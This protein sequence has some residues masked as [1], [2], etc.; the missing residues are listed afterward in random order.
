MIHQVESGL[1]QRKGKALTNF[2][3]TLPKQQSDLA[4]EVLKNPYNLDFLSLGAESNER[5]LENALIANIKK[6]LLE[7][8]TGFSFMGQQYYLKVGE[9]EYYIDLLFYHTRLHCYVVVELKV[10]EF[11]PEFAGKLEFYLTAVDEQLKTERDEPTIGLLLC[12]SMDRVVVEY[13]LRNKLKPMSVAAYK[14][15]IPKEL[16]DELPTEEALKEQLNIEVVIPVKPME[17]KLARLK[18]LIAQTG[19]EKMEKE[20]D[21]DEVRYLFNEFI[22]DFEKAV[23]QNL[24]EITNEFAKVEIGRR[25]NNTSSPYFMAADLEATLEKEAVYQLGLGIRMEG[26]K[27]GGTKAFNIFKDLIINLEQYK[28][29]VGTEQHKPWLEK[30]YHQKW[31]KEEVN[32]LADKWCEQL[33]DEIADRIEQLSL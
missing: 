24:S 8:G 11:V 13:S 2:E 25:I 14:H 20:R 28:Y 16:R 5:D 29:G 4:K 26:F 15:A 9:K 12:K 32:N 23:K 10:T 6:F 19:R 17:E 7:L 1:F 33:F 3:L 30:L 21:K 22:L 27:R 18:E 31:T